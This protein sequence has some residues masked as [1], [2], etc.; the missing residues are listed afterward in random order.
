MKV[1]ARR[2]HIRLIKI[3]T[4]FFLVGIL[5]IGGIL[6]YY[7]TRFSQHIDRAL[8]EKPWSD[9][10]VIYGAPTLLFPGQSLDAN[11]LATLLERRGYTQDPE[12]VH[13]PCFRLTE[14]GSALEI[15]QTRAW[16]PPEAEQPLRALITFLNGKIAS[17]TALPG[18][19]KLPI[20]LVA[21]PMLS[22][23]SGG[24]RRQYIPFHKLPQP[25]IWALLAAEDRHFFSHPGVDI[26]GIIRS[27][28]RNLNED[29]VA[30]GGSTLTQQLAKNLFLSPR[31]KFSRKFHE[32]LLA[33]FLELR[34][35]KKKIFE[36]YANQ[37]YLGQVASL[38]VCGFAQGAEAYFGKSLNQLTLG[39]CA[40]LAGMV[41]SPNQGNPF[42]D[43]ENAMAR[44]NRV[45]AAMADAG[46]IGPT[47][48]QRAEAEPPPRPP[49]NRFRDLPAPYYLDWLA[50]ELDS[51]S[52]RNSWRG[53][54]TF[55]ASLNLELQKAAEEGLAAGLATVRERLRKDYPNEPA[56]RL[57][58]ALV[59]V[60]PR[61]GQVLAM[62][63][64][65]D[66][67]TSPFNRATSAWRQAGSVLKPFIYAFCLDEGKRNP[68]LD[69]TPQSI[70]VDEPVSIPY[71]GRVYRPHNYLDAYRGSV[72]MREALAHSLNAATV[73]LA[74]RV[75]FSPLAARI[76]RLGFARKAQ[77]YPSL[78]LGTLDVTPLEISRAYTAFYCSGVCRPARPDNPALTNMPPPAPS[79][80][81]FSGWTAHEMLDMMRGTVEMG[82]ARG[83]RTQGIEF[84]MAAKTGTAKDGWFVG[85]TGNLIVC[86]W[87]GYDQQRELPLAGGSSALYVFADFIRRARTIYP[88]AALPGPRPSWL[89]PL[90][91]T[92][93][94]PGGSTSEGGNRPVIQQKTR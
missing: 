27:L 51:P 50:A 59:A 65:E 14:S 16:A 56:D 88:V 68:S 53:G 73:R 39:E 84:P 30:E 19:K 64:G 67:A 15:R 81:I 91:Q 49:A 6:L 31:R 66:Y 94:T 63:G 32:A 76:D 13:T 36:I 46:F 25:L 17:I 80:A 58:G 55:F 41:R 33:L 26:T 42:R 43:P 10:P 57:Q 60:S 92:V 69:L 34:I 22:A 54:G 11:A 85:L 35:P 93:N 38:G 71:G 24:V 47:E 21:P 18:G 75:G 86:C 79:P 62:T 87:V 23:Q 82:T 7:Y 40:M 28:Y 5:S 3:L 74:A 12:L 29:R 83:L 77:P 70:V 61:T 8:Q 48:R 52:W 37:V 9:F 72:T 90:P 78:A 4:A 45:L 20:L 1:K 2:K 44:R 89:P